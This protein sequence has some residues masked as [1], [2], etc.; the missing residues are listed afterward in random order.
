[1]DAKD[2]RKQVRNV[3]QENIDTLVKQEVTAKLR[4]E[5]LTDVKKIREITEETLKTRLDG[6]EKNVNGTLKA[7]ADRSRAVQ[8]FMVQTVQREVQAQLRNMEITMLA[9]QE[10]MAG[11]LGDVEEFNKLVDAKKLEIEQ[12][13]Q[14]E[15]EKAMAEAIKDQAEAA[16]PEAESPKTEEAPAL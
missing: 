12:K 14:A 9:W 15:K 1:M 8:G 2:I 11:K 6:L 5:L 10:V 3:V 16:A 4:D 7:N 13:R